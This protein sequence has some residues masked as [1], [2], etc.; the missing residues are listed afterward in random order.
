MKRG[1]KCNKPSYS[2]ATITFNGS[3]E[4]Y[5]NVQSTC[6]KIFLK[7]VV[8]ILEAQFFRGRMPKWAADNRRLQQITE[9]MAENDVTI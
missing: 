7:N 3:N 4:S 8:K 6:R 2:I 5:L 9:D 1:R